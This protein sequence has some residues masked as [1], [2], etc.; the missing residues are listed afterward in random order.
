M[1]CLLSVLF[2][3]EIEKKWLSGM[4]VFMSKLE[5]YC[6][7]SLLPIVCMIFEVNYLVVLV[8]LLF[9]DSANGIWGKETANTHT[10]SQG[11]IIMILCCSGSGSWIMC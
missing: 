1:C 4:L 3:R 11:L 10:V 5:V 6:R 2:M 7:F 8:M 9:V